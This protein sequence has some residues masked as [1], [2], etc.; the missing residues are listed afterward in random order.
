VLIDRRDQPQHWPPYRSWKFDLRVDP[1]VN[2]LLYDPSLAITKHRKEIPV[3]RL[4]ACK[5]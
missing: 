3:L 1:S 2:S 4:V 5:F